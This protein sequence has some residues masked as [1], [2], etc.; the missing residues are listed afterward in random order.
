[1]AP[2]TLVAEALMSSGRVSTG[3]TASP[4]AVT[5]TRKLA[6]GDVLSWLS[7]AVH[8]TV[9]TPTAKVEPETGRHDTGTFGPST[10]SLAVTSNVTCAPPGPV[11]GTVMSGGV[12]MD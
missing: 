11:A 1:M 3:G 7:V 12:T 10:T 2:C 5:M 6:G 4:A 9:V 8:A